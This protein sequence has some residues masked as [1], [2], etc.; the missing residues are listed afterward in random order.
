MVFNGSMTA[1]QAVGAGSS[2][3]GRSNMFSRS[4]GGHHDGNRSEVE[5]MFA[6]LRLLAMGGVGLF[7]LLVAKRSKRIDDEADA[8]K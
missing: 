7:Y 3:A 4:L 1:F 2:P 8:R 5:M 6:L